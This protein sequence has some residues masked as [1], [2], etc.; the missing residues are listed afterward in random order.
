V[1]IIK[2]LYL[3]LESNHLFLYLV[4]AAELQEWLEAGYAFSILLGTRSRTHQAD[5]G[6]KLPAMCYMKFKWV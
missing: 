6:C 5:L 3:Q 2:D 1:H 4:N